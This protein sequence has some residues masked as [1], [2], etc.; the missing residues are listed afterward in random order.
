M[1]IIGL[2]G[3]SGS[4]KGMVSA[5]FEYHNI[6]TVDTDAVYHEVILPPSACL[7]E[8]EREFGEEIIRNDKTLDRKKLASIV[9]S[10]S[11]KK[12]QKVLNSITHKYVISR[13]KELILDHKKKGTKILVFDVPLLFESG[14]DTMC[15]FTISVIADREIRI[16]RI[17]KRDSITRDAAIARIN[18]QMPDDFYTSRSNYTVYNNGTLEELAKQVNSI[19]ENPEVSSL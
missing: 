16:G 11:T 13:C 7:D 12:K 4:G 19:I 14:F 10:D 3:P 6:P 8:L 2:T 18:A 1:K 17:V 5:V 9:F 15:D